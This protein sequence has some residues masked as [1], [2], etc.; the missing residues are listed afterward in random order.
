M[1][2]LFLFCARNEVWKYQGWPGVFPNLF[3]LA[4]KGFVLAAA[5]M[6]I[7]IA[8]DKMFGLKRDMH[9]PHLRGHHHDDD[10]LH[11]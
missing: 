9:P 4:S 6:V 8:A 5:A 1:T 2:L 10:S 11:D 7:T 3:R